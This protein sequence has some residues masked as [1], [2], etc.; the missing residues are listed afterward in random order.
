MVNNYYYICK[1][2]INKPGGNTLIIN[3]KTN[4][5]NEKANDERSHD[6]DEY[7]CICTG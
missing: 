5:K 4:K 6:A 3:F 7:W 1:E 2:F